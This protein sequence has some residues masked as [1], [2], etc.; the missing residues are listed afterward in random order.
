[1]AVINLYSMEMRSANAG[2]R[3]AWAGVTADDAERSTEAGALWLGDSLP[4]DGSPDCGATDWSTLVGELLDP[5]P[6]SAALVGASTGSVAAAATAIAF[7]GGAKPASDLSVVGLGRAGVWA[8]DLAAVRLPLTNRVSVTF[9]AVGTDS[10]GTK[11]AS[12]STGLAG[13]NV[14]AKRGVI[15]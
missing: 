8:P 5:G 4:V 14:V 15:Q 2:A 6:L 3:R 9:G 13:V 7:A 10:S 1:M 12:Y 11:V